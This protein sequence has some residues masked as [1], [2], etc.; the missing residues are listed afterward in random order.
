MEINQCPRCRTRFRGEIKVCPVDGENLVRLQD[1]LLGRTIAGR[2][3]IEDKIGGGGMGVVYRAS[4][5]VIGR[6][7]AI[8]FLHERYMRDATSR[9]RFLGEARAANQINHENIIDIT[10]FGET[11]DGLVYLVM[12]YLHG[13]GLDQEISQGPL[14]AARALR[15]ATQVAAGLARAHE[16]DVIHRDVKPGNVFLVRRRGEGDLV[17]LLDFG[18]ARF[19]RELRITDRGTLLGTAE[20]IAPEQLRDGE[21]SPQTD[22]YALGCVLFEMLVGH[23]PFGG[24]MTEVLVKQM[25]DAPPVPSS[26]NSAVPKGV[27]G[28]VLKMLSKDPA[29]RHRDA[30]HLVEELRTQLDALQPSASEPASSVEMHAPPPSRPA[31][32]NLGK[33]TMYVPAERDEWATRVENYR[34]QLSELHPDGKLPGAIREAMVS[35]EAIVTE[36][37]RLR[38]ALVDSAQKQA[39]SHEELRATRLRIGRALDELAS[40]ESKLAR[41]YE[42][43]KEAVARA[44]AEERDVMNALLAR[45]SIGH[46]ALKRGAVLNDEDALLLQGLS[47][48]LDKVR[49][50]YV[51]A[52]KIEREHTA[53]RASLEDVRFQIEQLKGRLAGLNASSSVNQTEVQERVQTAEIKLRGEMERMVGHA[54]QVALYLRSRAQ[55]SGSSST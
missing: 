2:Y 23:P 25:R 22:L 46:I 43:E 52:Q 1:P 45:P 38:S 41:G 53:K 15:I 27:D 40:D 49:T 33:L 10:D 47:M 37:A 31:A 48:V 9:K 42:S 6:D 30:Y 50:S 14:V 8:K 26:L 4:H 39:A 55:S 54:E 18:V 13:R 12:E 51:H 44:K 21:I 11:E 5:Q 3:L 7:V 28:L 35:L 36:A 32:A 29:R 17:K 34:K 16:L 24:N 20:Y 19:E